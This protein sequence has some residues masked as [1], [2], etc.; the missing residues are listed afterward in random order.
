MFHIFTFQEKYSRRPSLS[1]TDTHNT[2]LVDELSVGLN[3]RLG[4]GKM[5]VLLHPL[6]VHL[7]HIIYASVETNK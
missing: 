4:L 1:H 5:S 3:L 2:H 6:Q 7:L